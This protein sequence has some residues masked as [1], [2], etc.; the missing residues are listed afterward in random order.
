MYHHKFEVPEV[1][2]CAKL[3]SVVTGAPLLCRDPAVFG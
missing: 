3:M 2:P 1:D